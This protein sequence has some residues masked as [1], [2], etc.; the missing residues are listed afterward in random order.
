MSGLVSHSPGRS[1][2]ERANEPRGTQV[3]MSMEGIFGKPQERQ[4]ERA[5]RSHFPL[6]GGKRIR[7]AGT[8]RRIREWFLD[9]LREEGTE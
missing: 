2:L 9:E 1:K 5:T 8:D 7:E 3:R 6:R 4:S